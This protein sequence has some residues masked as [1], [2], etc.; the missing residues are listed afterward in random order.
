VKRAQIAGSGEG[1]LVIAAVIVLLAL[2]G[3]FTWV[4]A[5]GRRGS[6]PY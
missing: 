3:G 4:A 2:T 6:N 5:S 1:L